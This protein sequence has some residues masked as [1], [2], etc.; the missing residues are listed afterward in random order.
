MLCA[1]R[2][3]LPQNILLQLYKIMVRPVLEYADSLW[4]GLTLRDQRILEAVQYRS[5]RMISGHHGIPY[6]SYRSVYSQLRLPSLTFRRKLH[7][8][9]ALYKLMN[10]HCPPTFSVSYLPPD[11]LPLN[12]DIPSETQITFLR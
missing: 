1:L 9:I 10:G 12:L 8:L 6:P 3:K 5:A 4:A 7:T 2:K 11:H